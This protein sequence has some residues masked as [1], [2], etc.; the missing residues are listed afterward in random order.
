MPKSSAR[1]QPVVSLLNRTEVREPDWLRIQMELAK[2][3]HFQANV[4]RDQGGPK[5]NSEAKEFDRAAAKIMRGISRIP[6]EYRDRAKQLLSEW[7]I[8]VTES[9]ETNEKL[10]GIIRRCETEGQDYIGEI[11]SLLGDASRLKSQLA[12]TLK[13]GQKSATQDTA[14]GNRN[15]HCRA[16]RNRVT[17]V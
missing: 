12:G 9:A 14:T 13:R 17:D 3:L 16:F 1:L 8:S 2:A 11:E 10:P 6:S 4:V 5:S 15:P 7:N